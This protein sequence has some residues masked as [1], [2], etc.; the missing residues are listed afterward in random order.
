MS[1]T[2][3]QIVFIRHQNRSLYGELIQVM[4]DR[5][6]VWLRPLALCIET[7]DPEN[8]TVFDVRNGPDIICPEHL[9]QPAVDADWLKLLEKMSSHKETC[10]FTQANQHLRLFLKALF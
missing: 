10:D 4:T 8:C 2:T 1:P 6:T 5:R 7:L 9:H 3:Y